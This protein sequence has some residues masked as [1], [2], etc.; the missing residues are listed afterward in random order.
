MTRV[1][2]MVVIERIGPGKMISKKSN[3][4]HNNFSTY[5]TVF[6]I[7]LFALPMNTTF[8]LYMMKNM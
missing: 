1:K 8:N 7:M 5:N 3:R 2:E 4:Y 6:I